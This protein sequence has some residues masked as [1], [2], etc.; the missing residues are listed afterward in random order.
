M[1]LRIHQRFFKDPHMFLRDVNP[2]FALAGNTLS[3]FGAI[4]YTTHS[5]RYYVVGRQ[6]NKNL[7]LTNSYLDNKF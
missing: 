5:L 6:K 1:V 2:D 3:H 4:L 7:L